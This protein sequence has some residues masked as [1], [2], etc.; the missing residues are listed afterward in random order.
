VGSRKIWLW[1]L[2]RLLSALD[3]IFA[4]LIVA[5]AA[6]AFG[7]ACGWIPR[8][9]AA[10]LSFLNFALPVTISA[11]L[12]L[13]IL[14]K[15]RPFKKR[16]LLI[17][18]L[19]LED[20]SKPLDLERLGFSQYVMP[21]PLL[22]DKT[23]KMSLIH[24][25]YQIKC[26]DGIFTLRYQG[27]N[28][29][30]E[31]SRFFRD[32]IASDSAADISLMDVRVIDKIKDI[33]LKWKLLKDKTYQKLMEIYFFQPLYP[34]EEFSIEISCRWPGT[35]MRREDYVYYPVHY[36]QKGVRKLIGEL[37]LD[38]EPTY[39]EGVRFNGKKLELE[40]ERPQITKRNERYLIRWEIEKPQNIYILHFGRQ[41]I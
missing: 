13:F 37:V 4:T 2:E 26:Y 8:F 3:S 24:Q 34:G 39:I 40:V 17:R 18:S 23:H 7:I 29:G 30:K 14:I 41:D 27:K 5:S 20:I 19:K 38:L 28:A 16:A 25:T 12:L 31:V 33:P 15:Y 21:D 22:V 9:S 1:L 10:R 11:L 32:S 6:Y 35:F 36:Y